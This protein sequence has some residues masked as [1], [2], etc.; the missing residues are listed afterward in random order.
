MEASL[1]LQPFFVYFHMKIA[2]VH[3]WLTGMRGGEKCLEVLCEIFPEAPIYTLLYIKGSISP[4]LESKDIHTSF[5][6]RF[7]ML[8]EKYRSYVPLFPLAIESLDFSEYDVVISTSHCVAKGIKVRPGALHISY[9][10]T[11]M[12]YVWEMYDEYFGKG[13]AG[14][15]TRAAMAIFAPYLRRWDRKTASRV[16]YYIANS[17]NVRQ[18]IQRL[19]GRDAEVIFPPVDTNLFQLSNSDEGFYLLVSALVPYKRVDLAVEA[20]NQSGDRLFIVGKGPED[21]KLREMAKSNVVFLG[22]RTDQELA[23]LYACCR[24]LIFPGEED[25]GIVP[26]EAMA[27][28]KPVIAFAKGGALETVVEGVTGTFFKEQTAAACLERIHA[29]QTMHLDPVT[30]RAHALHFGREVYKKKMSAFIE[31]KVT[32]H[33]RKI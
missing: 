25:F 31:V 10:H 1:I 16:H 14:F 7:P 21:R 18:R 30:I 20:F 11:P 12:R 29:L 19:Y 33:F 2:L 13:R 32:E 17:E 22:W 4:A 28:G 23:E 24:A 9:I 26:L 5:I 3:D 27:S 15:M 8:E 6:Q